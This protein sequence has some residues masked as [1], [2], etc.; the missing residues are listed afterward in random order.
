MEAIGLIFT[1]TS[2]QFEKIKFYENI[3]ILMAKVSLD[4]IQN[5]LE[6]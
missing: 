4:R 6:E 1:C 3:N 5:L 2:F